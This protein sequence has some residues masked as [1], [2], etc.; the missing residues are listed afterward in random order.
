MK[1]NFASATGALALLTILACGGAGGGES[2]QMIAFP[3][4]AT[5]TAVGAP[6]YIRP[7]GLL[8]SDAS[9]YASGETK[10]GPIVSPTFTGAT[11][12]EDVVFTAYRP[13]GAELGRATVTMSVTDA[14]NVK[15]GVQNL[16]VN[17][18]GTTLTASL[19]PAP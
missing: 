10:V 3:Y 11:D 5:N 2:S 18:N 12:T 16:I 4:T 7:L 8:E 15:N 14:F 6:V 17:F 19:V 1:L 13:G 9:L